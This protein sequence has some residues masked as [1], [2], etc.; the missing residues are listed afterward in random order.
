MLSPTR[1]VFIWPAGGYGWEAGVTRRGNEHWWA[2]TLPRSF[3]YLT[4]PLE[5]ESQEFD[6]FIPYKCCDHFSEAMGE[7]L[8]NEEYKEKKHN[9]EW[10]L[11]K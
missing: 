9:L 11:L 7:K 10:T 1:E 8:V 6:T 2:N 3:L 4:K 5:F